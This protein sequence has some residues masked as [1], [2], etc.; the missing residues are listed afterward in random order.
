MLEGDTHIEGMARVL[1]WLWVAFLAATILYVVVAYMLL[2]SRA[3]GVAPAID[4]RA[5]RPF[6]WIAGALGLG[7]A[8]LLRR[9]LLTRGFRDADA[10][11]IGVQSAMVVGWAAVEAVA[12][13]GLVLVIL[14]GNLLD[15]APF[16]LAAFLTLAWQRP[17]AEW[18]RERIEEF[19]GRRGLSSDGS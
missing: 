1:H 9:R 8:L 6:F 5:V 4:T 7:F 10:A 12:I 2:R 16:F 18:L 3:P 11:L 19:H 14:G 13:V 15:G 17:S